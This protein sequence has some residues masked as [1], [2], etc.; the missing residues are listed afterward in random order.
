MEKD[1]FADVQLDKTGLSEESFYQSRDM[2]QDKRPKEFR[3]G[4]YFFPTTVSL[5]SQMDLN[6]IEEVEV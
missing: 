1:N 4:W 2:C 3:F 5:T 6:G